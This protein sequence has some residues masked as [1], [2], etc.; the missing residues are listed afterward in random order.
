MNTLIEDVLTLAREGRIIGAVE[1]VSLSSVTETAWRSAGTEEATL[2]VETSATVETDP[3]R[4]TD[5]SRTS[6]G[7]PSNT[8]ARTP[9][10]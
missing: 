4:L 5:C 1:P 8:P 3:D 9:R 7:T 2:T 6:F 10:W